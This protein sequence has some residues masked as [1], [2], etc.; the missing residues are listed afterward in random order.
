M[1]EQK[2]VTFLW[3]NNN[4]EEAVNFYTSVFTNASVKNTSRYGDNAPMPKGTALVVSFELE[5]QTF[6]ALNGGPTFHFTPAISLMV[7]CTTQDEVDN[8]WEKLSE[9][10]RKDQCG[11][12]TDKFGLSWQIVPTIIGELMSDKDRNKSNRVMQALM[13]MTKIEIDVLKKAYEGQ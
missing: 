3:F 9:G 12:L 2:I 6:M 11:W 8:L 5:G 7:N 1:S 13:K 10:G 4:A